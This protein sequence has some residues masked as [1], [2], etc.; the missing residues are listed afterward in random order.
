MKIEELTLKKTI[1]ALKKKEISSKELLLHYFKKIEGDQKKDL[2]INAIVSINKERALKEAEKNHLNQPLAGIPIVIKDNM[3]LEGER[4]EC[5]SD[6]LKGY[7]SPYTSGVCKKL[8]EN[9][10]II[11]GRTNM[12][13]FAM[14]SSNETSKK[15]IVRNPINLE[16]IP[17]GSSGGAAASV[18]GNLA[19]AAIGSD[20]GGSIRQPA[21]CCGIVGLKP[22]YGRVSR[23]GLVAFASSLDQ[24]GPITKT[25]EDAAILL[26]AISGY[27]QLDSTSAKKK[28]LNYEAYLNKSLSGKK[29]GILKEFFSEKIS[30]E[31]LKSLEKIIDFFKKQNCQIE[32]VSIPSTHYALTSY[33]IIATAE[34]S[35][36]LARFDG[37][38]YG[39]RNKQAKNLNETYFLSRSEGFGEEVKQRILLGT[40]VLSSGYYDDYYVKAHRIRNWMKQ[41]FTEK[42]SHFDVLLSPTTPDLVFKIGEKIKNPIEMYLSDSFTTPSNLTGLPSISIPCGKDT[43]GLPISFQLIGKA[44]EEET[45]LN[46]AHMYQKENHWEF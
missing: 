44:F 7:I 42:L 3:H 20:T 15:G 5:C 27:D 4:V 28:V 46:L 45:I 37:I 11:F 30:P 9:G 13:E 36:N 6:I 43:K 34:A 18:S 2:K 1:D 35:S 38:R 14:G 16:Y 24:I 31:I 10:A 19:I 41:E 21:A 32:E 33:Y 25:A 8:I 17:G 22:T 39:A 29:I 26:N 40:Y 12:D 23:Y